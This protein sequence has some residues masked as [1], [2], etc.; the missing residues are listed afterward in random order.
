MKVSVGPLLFTPA[1]LYIF[2]IVSECYGWQYGRQII[3]INLC[4]NSIFTLITFTTK[5]IPISLFTHEGLRMAYQ[6]LMGTVWVTSLGVGLVI[7]VADYISSVFTAQSRY[8]FK[9]IVSL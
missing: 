1:I 5:F 9:G 4:I 7:F 2:Q 3:W 8:Y 6:N